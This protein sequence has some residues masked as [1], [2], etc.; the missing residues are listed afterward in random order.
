MWAKE[1]ACRTDRMSLSCAR[2][3]VD[4]FSHSFVRFGSIALDGKTGVGTALYYTGIARMTSLD[5]YHN[6]QLW[7]LHL[8]TTTGPWI[9]VIDCA[10]ME[11]HTTIA[12][13][14]AKIFA[15][16]LVSEYSKKLQR[17]V[18]LNPNAWFHRIMHILY[19]QIQPEVLDSIWYIRSDMDFNRLRLALDIPTETM[20]WLRTTL[21]IEPNRRLPPV[22][23][24]QASSLPR[25]AN[26][27]SSPDP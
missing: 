20:L 23:T 2:C 7:K 4:P 11:L 24:A 10:N 8:D 18:V 25:P 26:S 15:N 17:I 13:Q 19:K 6:I 9:W 22:P 1:Q 16:M 3:A 14:F 5:N 21:T 27:E 12:E